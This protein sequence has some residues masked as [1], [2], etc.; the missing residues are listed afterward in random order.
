M[1]GPWMRSSNLSQSDP[2]A[3]S[4]VAG[5]SHT[6]EPGQ[7]SPPSLSATPS[8]LA[9]PKHQRPPAPHPWLAHLLSG[10][11]LSQGCAAY[12]LAS[13][14]SL[15]LPG[16]CQQHYLS[17]PYSSNSTCQMCHFLTKPKPAPSPQF[18]LSDGG[19]TTQPPTW[20]LQKS[21]LTPSLPLIVQNNV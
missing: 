18:F 4:S 6:A 14:R 11:V 13:P 15:E 17:I 10:Q 16:A 12:W 20:E 3:W 8:P 19:S 1:A 21:T 2:K 7:H 9:H 5:H